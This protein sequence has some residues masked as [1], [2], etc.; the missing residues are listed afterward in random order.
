MFSPKVILVTGASSGLGRVTAEL[1]ARQGYRVFG[2]SRQPNRAAAGDFTMLSLDVRSA[3]SIETCIRAVREQAGRL[4]VLINNAGYI[5]PAAA[6][7]EISPAQLKALFETNFFGVVRMVN[8][9]LPLMRQQGG[10]QIINISSAAGLVAA[11]PFFGAYTASKHAL[12]GYTEALRYEVKPFG[13]RVSLVEPGYLKTAIEQ[14]IEAP[15]YP[16]AAYAAVREHVTALDRAAL[17]CGRDP[18][19]AARVVLELIQNP[20]PPL[21]RPVGLDAVNVV[22]LKRFFPQQVL[23]GVISW[24]FLRRNPTKPGLSLGVRRFFLDSRAADGLARGMLFVLLGTLVAVLVR[25][26]GR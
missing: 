16:L 6:G 12:E 15:A 13:I 17:Q 1:L 18:D 10:G 25:R 20:W 3:D 2:T 8:A 9:A 22:A 11:P 26:W 19:R 21:R 14:T 5:G 24:L 23:E 7:E 4:D